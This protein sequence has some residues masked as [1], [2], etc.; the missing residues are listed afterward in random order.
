MANEYVEYVWPKDEDVIAVMRYVE[1]AVHRKMWVPTV[2]PQMSIERVAELFQKVV[3]ERTKKTTT[4]ARLLKLNTR[5]KRL[6]ALRNFYIPPEKSTPLEL[7]AASRF[8]NLLGKHD[9]RLS[10]EEVALGRDVLQTLSCLVNDDRFACQ[11]YAQLGFYP[12]R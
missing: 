12:D 2:S 6:V 8:L 4:A 1:L 3:I 11:V 5:N 9:T 10:D 7:L